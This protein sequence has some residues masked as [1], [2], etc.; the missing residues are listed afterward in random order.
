MATHIIPSLGPIPFLPQTPLSQILTHHIH[1]EP[2][3]RHVLLSLCITP[4]EDDTLVETRESSATWAANPQV[5][6]SR[7]A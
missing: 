4:N 1:A 6:V 5:S 3:Y 2:A 7:K